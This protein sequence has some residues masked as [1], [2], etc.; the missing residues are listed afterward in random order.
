MNVKLWKARLLRLGRDILFFLLLLSGIEWWQAR[1][2]VQG[3]MPIDISRLPLLDGERVGFGS[4]GQYTL[5]YV[6]APWCG[7]CRLSA[8]NL[9]RLQS[10]DVHVQALALSWEDPREVRTF[11]SETGLR[12]PVLL[13]H[14]REET[15]LGIQS[16][17]SHFLVSPRGSIVKSWSGYTT[18]PG[19]FWKVYWNR[20]MDAIQLW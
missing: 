10:L 1:K 14:V 16:Y 20:W 2:M 8:S 4:A 9:N 13:G 3:S 11:V 6:F 12:V 5:L 19:F 17:P 7:V 15:A 18:T